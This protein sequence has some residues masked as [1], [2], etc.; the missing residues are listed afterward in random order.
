MRVKNSA[1]KTNFWLFLPLPDRAAKRLSHFIITFID[2]LEKPPLW[3]LLICMK[4]PPSIS[5][6]WNICGIVNWLLKNCR[7]AQTA[8]DRTSCNW[9]IYARCW[10]LMRKSIHQKR[11]W[12]VSSDSKRTTSALNIE[13]LATLR[14]WIN[15][16]GCEGLG[17]LILPIITIDTYASN[18]IH[19][20]LNHKWE[21][22]L[23]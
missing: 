9:I 23:S 22:L 8:N 6:F 7:V 21:N 4:S 1:I 19:I 16:N 18:F 20:C 12:K 11:E 2:P 13:C 14:D 15:W 3:E 17:E 5:Q 10:R